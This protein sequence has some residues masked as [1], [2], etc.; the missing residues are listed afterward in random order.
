[1][2]QV[3]S[4]GS[5]KVAIPLKYSP[6]FLITDTFTLSVGHVFIF[7][8]EAS[9]PNT[10][11]VRGACVGGREAEKYN[12]HPVLSYIDSVAGRRELPFHQ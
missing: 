5:L 3:D 1:M 7:Y 9:M 10:F 2:G 11:Y 12:W 8:C 6:L 4:P